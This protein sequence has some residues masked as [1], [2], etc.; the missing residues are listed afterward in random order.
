MAETDSELTAEKAAVASLALQ[1]AD[2]DQALLGTEPRRTELVLTEAGLS[3]KDIARLTGRNYDTVKT[4]IRR[5]R[6]K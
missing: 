4:T 3:I 5:A 6:K 1:I 2:R